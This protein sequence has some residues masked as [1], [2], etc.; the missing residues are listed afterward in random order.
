MLVYVLV[1]VL[2]LV[3]VFNSV[4]ACMGVL[5]RVSVLAWQ[6]CY[7]GKCASLASVLALVG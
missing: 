5:A 4:P 2:V 6:V 3:Y 1:L 7:P